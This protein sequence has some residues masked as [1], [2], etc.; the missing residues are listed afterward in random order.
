MARVITK[1]T[2]RN[3]GFVF[4]GAELTLALIDYAERNTDRYSLEYSEVQ[5]ETTEDAKGNKVYTMRQLSGMSVPALAKL[6]ADLNVPI[7]DSHPGKAEY[8]SAILAAQKG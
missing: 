3:N 2:N 8:V 7:L 4:E 6:A 5:D 1:V